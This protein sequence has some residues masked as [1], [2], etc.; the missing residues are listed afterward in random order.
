MSLPELLRERRIADL[1]PNLPGCPHG[2]E[3]GGHHLR[4]PRPVLVLIA[5]GLEKLRVREDDAE[6]IVQAME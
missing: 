6:L 5:F 3:R 1:G 4:G 2:F